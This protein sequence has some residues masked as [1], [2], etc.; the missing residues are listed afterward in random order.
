M[1]EGGG[2]GDGVVFPL[3]RYHSVYTRFRVKDIIAKDVGADSV[4]RPGGIDFCC[5]LHF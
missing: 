1:V 4:V 3:L 5:L 2:G